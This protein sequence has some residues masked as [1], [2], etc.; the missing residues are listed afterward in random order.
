MFWYFGVWTALYIPS[1]AETRQKNYDAFARCVEAGNSCGVFDADFGVGAIS[2]QIVLNSIACA[3]GL[4]L[5]I[6]GQVRLRQAKKSKCPNCGDWERLNEK[7]WVC[8]KCQSFVMQD[9]NKYFGEPNLLDQQKR[10]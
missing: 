4:L 10:P 5:W 2:T 7:P 1:I 3:V 8:A 9:V 6:L